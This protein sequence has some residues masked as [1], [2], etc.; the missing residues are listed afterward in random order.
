MKESLVVMRVT[1]EWKD[2]R[3]AN[4]ARIGQRNMSKYI[5]SMV[6]LGESLVDGTIIEEE[7]ERE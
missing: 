2:E 3:R 7:E 6:A 1:E 5:Q 4:M